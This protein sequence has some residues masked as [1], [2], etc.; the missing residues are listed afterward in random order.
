M[1]PM[2]DAGVIADLYSDAYKGATRGYFSKVASKMRR[3][4]G[5]IRQ[6]RRYV[7]SGRFLDIGT[8]G[9]FTAKAASDV[10]FESWGIEPD[11]VS[12][13]Y[14]RKNYP[15]ISVFHGFI[16][17]FIQ[18]PGGRKPFDVVYCSEV[19]EH[20][21][22]FNGF[23]S[24][25][26]AITKP[27]GILYLTTPD[28]NHPLVPKNILSWNAFCPPSHCV[29]FS[30]KSLTQLLLKHGFSIIRR[31]LALKPGLKVFALKR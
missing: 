9:G 31:Q 7:N 22:D 10:G 13:D 14:V 18:T 4:K 5:R 27:R 12:V 17:D 2:P 16:E 19:L 8:N 29:Y 20:V 6:L 30:I 24:A 21:P 1:D 23:L 3:S 26:S 25:I 15:E 28:I 11:P